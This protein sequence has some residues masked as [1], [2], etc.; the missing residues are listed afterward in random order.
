[1][2][3]NSLLS[4][5][6]AGVST[7]SSFLTLP[8]ELLYR[9]PQPE[10]WSA[11]EIIHHLADAELVN[12]IS[13]RRIIAEDEPMLR[14]WDQAEYCRALDYQRRPL[15]HAVGTISAL[16]H[17]NVELL[18]ELSDEQWIRTG[19]HAVAGRM[20]LRSVV[21]EAIAHLDE[22]LSQARAAVNGLP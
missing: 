11:A 16:R 1:M 2:R 19:I 5:Y 8:D 13:I 22:H 20:D 6:L 12:S 21:A 17:S 10:S 7:L 14:S 18:A 4:G 15:L 3:I 9:R